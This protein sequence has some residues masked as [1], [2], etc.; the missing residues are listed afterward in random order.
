MEETIINKLKKIKA[1][2]EGGIEGEAINA[3]KLL[4]ELIQKLI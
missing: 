3:K 2:A 1:L 4:D